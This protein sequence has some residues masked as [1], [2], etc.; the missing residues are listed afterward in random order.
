[1]GLATNKELPLDAKQVMDFLSSMEDK[2]KLIEELKNQ[3]MSLRADSAEY[4][5]KVKAYDKYKDILEGESIK[6]Y[7]VKL[8]ESEA[9]RQFEMRMRREF[10]IN[11]NEEDGEKKAKSRGGQIKF[12]AIIN[13]LFAWVMLNP[14]R[15]Q[16]MIKS[17]K[18]ETTDK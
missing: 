1:M 3:L 16:Q 12:E 5:K 2:D 6:Y 15:Y 14:M 8:E 17:Y 10:S 4:Q 9:L 13:Y 18:M 7:T 11:L